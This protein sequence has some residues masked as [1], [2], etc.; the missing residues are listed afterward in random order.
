MK[1]YNDKEDML[2]F[3]ANEI[4]CENAASKS[5]ALQHGISWD[6]L[7]KL[8]LSKA[9][10][11]AHFCV[12]AKD[13]YKIIDNLKHVKRL[14]CVDHNFPN[15]LRSTAVKCDTP[16]TVIPNFTSIAEP[17]EKPKGKINI[18]FARRFFEYRGTRIFAPAIKMVLE[19][20]SNVY[21][22]IAGSGPDEELIREDLRG[23]EDRVNITEYAASE[24]LEIHKDKHIAVVPTIMSEGTSLSLLEAMSAQCA[25]ICTDVGGLSNIVIDGFNGVFCEPTV[26]D[27]AEKISELIE[28]EEKRRII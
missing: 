27:V 25:V 13:S 7:T 10:E 21:V 22:T 26:D 24:T 14:V 17:C 23:F 3:L 9:R 16:F 15:W 2:I 18:I 11:I 5:I 6:W 12:K 1:E 8:N 20:H 28:N 4:A 19:K